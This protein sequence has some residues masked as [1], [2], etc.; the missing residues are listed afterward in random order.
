MPSR[1]KAPVANE[2]DRGTP[3]GFRVLELGADGLDGSGACRLCLTSRR[4]KTPTDRRL[5]QRHTNGLPLLELGGD[6]L[7]GSGGHGSRPAA[8]RRWRPTAWTEAHRWVFIFW[9]SG[10]VAMAWTKTAAMAQIGKKEQL[11]WD[12]CY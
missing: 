7:A 12:L 4:S 5:G 10:P 2:L 9:S 3:M 6:V 11:L 1:T 8:A